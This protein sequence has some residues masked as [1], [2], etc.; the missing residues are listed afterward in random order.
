V[1]KCDLASHLHRETTINTTAFTSFSSVSLLLF[2]D[3]LVILI[4]VF[5]LNRFS[6]YFISLFESEISLGNMNREIRTRLL[7]YKI[8][9]SG[10]LTQD[11]CKVE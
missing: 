3:V 4:K 6:F 2:L 8:G 9:E 1:G 5:A 11:C 7:K 10:V